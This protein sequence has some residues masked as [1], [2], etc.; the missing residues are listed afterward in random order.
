MMNCSLHGMLK[1]LRRSKLFEGD[2]IH[3]YFQKFRLQNGDFD[4][5]KAQIFLVPSINC[6]KEIVVLKQRKAKER[7]A[8][9]KYETKFYAAQAAAPPPLASA[10]Q[11]PEARRGDHVVVQRRFPCVVEPHRL[12]LLPALP[13][14]HGP[15]LHVVPDRQPLSLVVLEDALLHLVRLPGDEVALHPRVTGLGREKRSSVC[16]LHEQH[17]GSEEGG[18]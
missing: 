13:I 6:L 7:I 9:K 5:E 14:L 11:L 4:S 3:F 2:N 18:P 10:V 16:G 8:R 12:L 17:E 15:H 1:I